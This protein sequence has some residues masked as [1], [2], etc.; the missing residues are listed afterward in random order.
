MPRRY[1]VTKRA[2]LNGWRYAASLAIHFLHDSVMFAPG[3]AFTYTVRPDCPDKVAYLAGC[4]RPVRLLVILVVKGIRL[5]V[6][7]LETTF[8]ESSL[9]HWSSLWPVVPRRCG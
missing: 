3:S 5:T 8:L 6:F 1:S 4:Q 7:Q 2:A 9:C